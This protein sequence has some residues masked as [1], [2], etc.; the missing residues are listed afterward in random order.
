[1]NA[2]CGIF[3]SRAAAE[4]AIK[5]LTA[6]GAAD[7]RIVLLSSGIE[8]ERVEEVVKEA[9]S[10]DSGTAEKVGSALGRGIGIAGGIMLGGAVGSVFVPGVG[11]VLAAG[12]LA[13]ALL[14]TGGAALGAA[15]GSALDDKVVENLRHD[16][17]HL[18]EAAL[19]QGRSVLIAL[20]NDEREAQAM[21]KV[22][23]DAGAETLEHA[24]ETWW[25]ELRSAEEAAYK[26]DG[27][28]FAL[29][30]TLYR[31]GFEAALHPRLRGKTLAESAVS[32]DR[33]FSDDQHTEAFQR[34]YER[35][36]AY[37]QHL[38]ENFPP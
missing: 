5:L 13:A 38:L 33:Y 6:I 32:L 25:S 14:G 19:R 4:S 9:E 36:Q 7:D 16:Q 3:N 30:E 23:E 22:L 1:M 21:L 37:H 12:V 8:D 35:G 10:G 29:D 34:G 27:R 26:K 28:D 18:Y 31:R 24:R 20:P 2:V 11:S 15:A 17:L